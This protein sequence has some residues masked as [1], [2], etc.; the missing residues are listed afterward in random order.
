MYG[1]LTSTWSHCWKPL[2]I[3]SFKL[4]EISDLGSIALAHIS[5]LICASGYEERQTKVFSIEVDD[6]SCENIFSMRLSLSAI[7]KALDLQSESKRFCLSGSERVK[8][9]FS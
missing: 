2:K 6:L 7:G 5:F 4:S 1:F 9:T 8:M 3:D